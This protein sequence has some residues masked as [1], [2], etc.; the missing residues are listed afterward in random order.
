M[1]R[2]SKPRAAPAEAQKTDPQAAAPAP[3]A[4]NPAS[5]TPQVAPDTTGAAGAPA[6]AAAAAPAAPVDPSPA[7]K[8]AKATKPAAVSVK[9]P[10]K[11]RWRIGRHF[12]P[13]AVEIPLA[14][15]DEDQ[16]ERLKADPE[17]SCSWPG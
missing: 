12:T 14:D 9:G 17:L 5:G 4:P 13:E 11:G 16:I 10:A 8:A 3:A 7:P 1:S 2:P 6:S 15:L